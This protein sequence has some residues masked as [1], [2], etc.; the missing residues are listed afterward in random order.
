MTPAPGGVEP[1]HS[2]YPLCLLPTT[3]ATPPATPPAASSAITA[4]SRPSTS[5]PR[6]TR[7]RVL[8]ALRSS[9]ARSRRPSKGL[10]R[11]TALAAGPGYI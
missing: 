1:R 8:R 3:L 9:A 4:I 5:T 11:S 7:L 10:R 2:P 6:N